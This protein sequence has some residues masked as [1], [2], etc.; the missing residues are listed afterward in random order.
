MVNCG[1]NSYDSFVVVRFAPNSKTLRTMPTPCIHR[2]ASI[3]ALVIMAL[4]PAAAL[5]QGDAP[6]PG[7][8]WEVSTPEAQGLLAA[9]FVEIDEDI[10]AGTY[11]NVDRMVVVRDGYLVVSQRYE[12]DY[13]SISRGFRGAL[14]CGADICSDAEAKDPYNYYHPDIHPY[15]QGR[16]V[17]TLQSVTKSV[18]ATVIGAALHQ[19]AI[20]DLSTPLLAFFVAYDISREDARLEQATLEDLLTMRTGIEWH[21]QDRPLDETNTTLQLERSK[22]WIQFT[23]DQPSDADPGEK[24]SYNSGGS[25]LMS[26]VIRRATGILIDEY[27]EKH[28]FGPLGIDS[29][30]WKKTPKGL[31]DTEGG[32]YLEAEQ[33]AKIG[34]LYL[35]GGRWKG[36]RIL[37]E[38]FASAAT[39]RQVEKVN[40]S[41][42]GYGYQWWMLDQRNTDI[43]AGLGFG[44][45]YLLVFP[46]H[47]VIGVVHSWNVFGQ[48]V[49]PVLRDFI[50]AI[51]A[52]LDIPSP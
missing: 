28:L 21:E 47:D 8:A 2:A 5:A 7:S 30:H 36:V 9:P 3:C 10:R 22:D 26:G 4:F 41:G 51:F 45:Q 46:E 25:H 20:D 14:G 15:F 48:S 13:A 17:H 40:S 52:S 50:D 35:R 6:W 42:W 19:G 29:Y 23:L 32:L 12:H 37:D 11:G 43:W 18:A 16:D 24:W 34:Y 27:A 1:G 39:A 33:L 44:G 38:D 49:G 31:P